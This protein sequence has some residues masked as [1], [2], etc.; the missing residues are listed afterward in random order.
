MLYWNPNV[1]GYPYDLNKA[2][3]LIGESSLKSGFKAELIVTIGD[4][5]AAQVAQLVAANL[6]DIGGDI[7]VTQLVRVEP[8]AYSAKLQPGKEDYDMYKGYFTT[9]IIDPDELTSLNIVS[10]LGGDAAL[11]LYKNDQVDKLGTDAVSV[12]DPASRCTTSCNNSRPTTRRS[13]SST[14]LRAARR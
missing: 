1:K 4:P 14:I 12:I 2:K 11:T 8:A 7:T 10:N 6:K 3:Q 9:D 5:V 13:C